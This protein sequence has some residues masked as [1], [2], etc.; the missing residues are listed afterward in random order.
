MS[1]YV[2]FVKEKALKTVLEGLELDLDGIQVRRICFFTRSNVCQKK[3]K[4]PTIRKIKTSS[5]NINTLLT[6]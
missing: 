1:T 5:L 2:L 4:T 3:K 6:N